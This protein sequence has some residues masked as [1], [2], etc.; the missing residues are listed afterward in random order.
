MNK[1]LRLSLSIVFI[2][3]YVLIAM[4]PT[5]SM[6][7]SALNISVQGGCTTALEDLSTDENFNSEDY[8]LIEDDYSLQV[9]QIAESS[10]KE[11]FVYV[12]QPSANYKDL[13]ASSINISCSLHLK[14]NIKNYNLNFLNKQGVFYKYVVKGLTVSDEST[15]YYEVIS[16]FHQC[17]YPMD[18]ILI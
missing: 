16:I 13:R 11:L 17:S 2:V 7:V 8:P 9:I 3:L 4:I 15:R 10:E 14:E 12:Y 1:V 5:S 6:T 18:E